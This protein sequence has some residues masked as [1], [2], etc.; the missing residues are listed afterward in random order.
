MRFDSPLLPALEFQNGSELM[1][2][3]NRQLANW[4]VLH[5]KASGTEAA[6]RTGQAVHELNALRETIASDS[7]GSNFAK[8]EKALSDSS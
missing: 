6:A 7:R 5:K 3:I 1:P 2:W 8:S 4:N